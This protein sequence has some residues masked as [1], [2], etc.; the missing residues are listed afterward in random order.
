MLTVFHVLEHPLVVALGWALLHFMW[1]GVIVAALLALLLIPLSR[2]A[3]HLRYLVLCGALGVMALLPVTTWYAV[4]ISVPSQIPQ[5]PSEGE[6]SGQSDMNT[7]DL[8]IQSRAEVIS[9][10]TGNPTSREPFA[11]PIHTE[12][13]RNS[14][15]ASL[16]MSDQTADSE[17]HFSWLTQL[18]ILTS[19][20]VPW[21]VAAW[22]FGV[23]LLSVQLLMGWRAIQKIKRLAT[24]PVSQIWQDRLLRLAARLR[25]TRPV[26]LVES[27]LVAVPTVIGW[28]QPMILLPASVLTGLEP[29]QLEALL[30]HELAHI[31]RNDFIVNLIQTVIETLLFY[32]PAIWWLSRRIRAEREHCCDDIAV[33]A[34]GNTVTYAR[35]LATMEELR[36]RPTLTMAAD[37]GSLLSR[38]RRLICPAADARRSSWGASLMTIATIVTLSIGIY[39]GSKA[40]ADL[41][42]ESET[43]TQPKLEKYAADLPGNIR[44][45]LVGIGFHPSK[46]REWWKPDGSKL[47]QFPNVESG[48][49]V[50]PDS[51]ERFKCR[52]FQLEIR[53]L[54]PEH[55]VTARYDASASAKSSLFERELWTGR[56]A[57]G[58]FQSDIT[59]IRIGIT[60]DYFG[61]RQ[62]V[63]PSGKKLAAP[64]LTPELQ[65]L[66]NQVTPVKVESSGDTTELVL[67]GSELEKLEDC[68]EFKLIAVDVEE[69]EHKFTRN[70]A[71]ATGN[72]HFVFPIPLA[73]IARFEY[74][75]RPYRHWVT[76]EN[77]SLQ[78]DHDTSLRIKTET[79]AEEKLTES[80]QAKLEREQ[81][82]RQLI[83]AMTTAANEFSVGR[84]HIDFENLTDSRIYSGKS[85][86]QLVKTMGNIDWLSDGK[87]WRIDYDGQLPQ[88]GTSNLNPDQWSTG[89]DGE[90][91]FYW[92]RSSQRLNIGSTKGHSSQY[93]PRDL[94]WNPTNGG[95]DSVLNTLSRPET[96]IVPAK[97]EGLDGYRAEYSGSNGGSWRW[98][99][100]ICPQRGHLALQLQS[101]SDDRLAWECKLS[102]LV[103]VQ[104]QVW[105]PKTIHRT[106]FSWRGGSKR[107]IA[108]QHDFKVTKFRQGPDEP[109]QPKEFSVQAPFGT[110]VVNL[111]D[112]IAYQNDVWWKELAPLLQQKFQWP[113]M[114]LDR[115]DLLNSSVLTQESGK[116]APG[117]GG[118]ELTDVDPTQ[119]KQTQLVWLNSKPLTWNQLAGKVTLVV[120]WS[121]Q[122]ERGMEVLA[123]LKRLHHTYA[124][125][126]LQIIA[127]HFPER[128]EIV[129]SL[130]DEFQLPYSV[131]VDYDNSLNGT[132]YNHFGVRGLPAGIFVDQ[133]RQLK[134]ITNAYELPEQLVRLLAA[135]GAKNPP[136]IK[137]RENISGEFHKDIQSVW[138]DAVS[139]APKTASIVGKVVDGRN[140]PLANVQ[141]QALLALHLMNGLNG[142][143]LVLPDFKGKQTVQTDANGLFALPNLVKGQYGLEITAPGKAIRK[144]EIALSEG[145]AQTLTVTLNFSDFISGQVLSTNGKPIANATLKVRY[146][147]HDPDNLDRHTIT[148]GAMPV[149]SSDAQGHFKFEKLELGHYTFD[150]FAD[151][152]ESGVAKAV[153]LGRSDVEVKLQPQKQE[154]ELQNPDKRDEIP[155]SKPRKPAA[156]GSEQPT[157]SR[158][159]EFEFPVDAEDKPLDEILMKLA[160]TGKLKLQFDLAALNDAKVSRSVLCNLKISGVR[161]K[162]VLSLLL[163]PLQL[164]FV[165]EGDVLKIT[166]Q[167]SADKAREL[168]DEV[169]I[170]AA[171]KRGVAFLKSQQQPDGSWPGLENQSGSVT[172][173]ATVALLQAGVPADDPAIQKAL[174]VLRKNDLKFIYTVALQTIAF[175]AA[176]PKVDA[177]LIRRHIAWIEGAQV[178]D[179]PAKGGWSYTGTRGARADGSCS[180]FAV[181]GLHAAQKAGFAVQPRTWERV[182]QYWLSTQLN[183]GQWGYSVGAPATPTMTLA[184]I[185][186]L[187]TAQRM[188][189]HDAEAKLREAAIKKAS[190]HVQSMI[191]RL[192]QTA[193]PFYGLHSLERAGN[194]TGTSRYHRSVNWKF[195]VTELLLEAQ[196]QDG[197]WSTKADGF[198]PSA[199]ESD[200]IAT[201]FALLIL[202][203]KSEPP[204]IKIGAAKSDQEIQGAT[205]P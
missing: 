68:A 75:L 174:P 115:L 183:D 205:K 159:L 111:A 137:L 5:T 134:P 54:P 51:P 113:Q 17:E 64:D 84:M 9:P 142:S 73:R 150:V 193:F 168:Q 181:L 166:S 182:S 190:E 69:G 173:M 203:G 72:R 129:K 19:N 90:R 196:R 85:G 79:V 82:A 106:S 6:V 180:R 37:G 55:S 118:I 58:P 187:A 78:P 38:I 128:P 197:A 143:H 92:E 8:T 141:I 153:L 86:N 139:K 146:R 53:G 147:H 40:N 35:A 126:G 169:F 162:S 16:A 99:A 18:R 125:H 138:L 10:F 178:L 1:Q 60:T 57:A 192:P 152:F 41:K 201:S 95:L 52:E 170:Q 110:D 119:V 189:P 195:V 67:K 144:Q 105:Y 61:R 47:A 100:F 148:P 14:S 43:E 15:V 70:L 24:T 59:S 27:A 39:L 56:H 177:E 194:L 36:G 63:D 20:A 157:E 103:E 98:S 22:L 13:A 136:L 156:V 199:A 140:Q 28:L 135:A 117:L 121:H 12:T 76:F 149:T 101:F 116:V 26:K 97:F 186:G 34:C 122:D 165:L 49:T 77:V 33:A 2:V 114:P 74:R 163:T 23:L 91:H 198:A 185:G 132:L 164:G 42:G 45:E 11:P 50:L 4:A 3:S 104:P 87:R 200:L 188:L 123:A 83:S 171:L 158:H 154:P 175:C 202:G 89:F 107:G 155:E 21:L 65:K 127:V 102:D 184:G 25:V 167:E 48:V 191:N 66:Y 44:V 120:F 161:A 160:S 31:R 124:S 108:W 30:A 71:T 29:A 7:T 109:I 93:T 204:P 176:S 81:L 88:S 112:G 62:A 80:A 179:G 172:A 133:Q 130:V 145:E 94:F 32:H 131:A 151:G 96:K 46:D